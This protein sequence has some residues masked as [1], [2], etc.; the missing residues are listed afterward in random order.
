[1]DSPV[2]FPLNWTFCVPEWF[3][4]ILVQICN[5]VKP[6]TQSRNPGLS[7]EDCRV[8]QTDCE[9]EEGIGSIGGESP[10][11]ISTLKLKEEEKE[12]TTPIVAPPWKDIKLSGPDRTE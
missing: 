6:S 10:K 11:A 2:C 9:E 3:L 8:H 12:G 4:K 1:M 7:R 5:T